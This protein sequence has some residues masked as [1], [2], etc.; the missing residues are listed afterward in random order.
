MRNDEKGFVPLGGFS[1]QTIAIVAI[2]AGV[3]AAG[4]TGV[5]STPWTPDDS[6]TGISWR[7]YG[8][9]GETLSILGSN[10]SETFQVAPS[11]GVVKDPDTGKEIAGVE[12]VL[13]V[14]PQGQNVDG[15][16]SVDYTYSISVL[17]SDTGDEFQATSESEGSFSDTVPLGSKE[18]KQ[19]WKF[20]SAEL[21]LISANFETGHDGKI[22]ADA[23]V[24]GTAQS[25]ETSSEDVSGS[26]EF[27]YEAETLT[28]NSD[29]DTGEL[30]ITG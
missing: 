23:T 10:D 3:F 25:G 30:N 2:V 21:V 16:I 11:L 22:T 24:T 14:E 8:P 29:V 15:P 1:V 19:L 13:S 7:I 4:Y 28:I 12:A 6:G 18:S 20:G 26:L 27:S 5:I 17:D 9:D